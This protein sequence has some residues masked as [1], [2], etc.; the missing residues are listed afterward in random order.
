MNRKDALRPRLYYYYFFS[1]ANSCNVINR[2]DELPRKIIILY[3]SSNRSQLYIV[4]IHYVILHPLY[5][6]LPA[7][8]AHIYNI[9]ALILQNRPCLRH[10]HA[11]PFLPP[12][13]R[14][15]TCS[16]GCVLLS[17]I[18]YNII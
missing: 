7:L 2:V 11:P 15:L 1:S 4:G 10:P 16:G 12:I 8:S 6:K 5:I 9:N 14:Y 17:F 18:Y 3:Q 13:S